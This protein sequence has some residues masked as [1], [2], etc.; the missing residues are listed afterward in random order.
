LIEHIDLLREV[1]RQV[2]DRRPFEVQAIVVL[3]EHLH[4]MWKLPDEDADYPGRW[5]AI[6][7]QFSQG[8][9]KR[10]VVF[11]KTPKGDYHLWQPRYWEHTLRDEIDWQ[12]YLDYI[13]FNPVKHGW[14]N[15]VADWPYSSFHRYVQRG[16]LP[17][18]WADHHLEVDLG[19]YGE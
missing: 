12:R 1:F 11:P 7:S 14:V 16:W 8:I 5:R 19:N 10:G 15:R 13:H 9:K 17:P 2:R 3:P 6:K 4:T 18:D